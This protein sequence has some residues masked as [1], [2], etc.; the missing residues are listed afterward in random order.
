MYPDDHAPPHFH[1]IF[2]G[3]SALIDLRSLKIIRG[4]APSKVLAEAL[5]VAAA[6]LG[7]L[8]AKWEE[9]NERDD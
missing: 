7:D 4:D 6:N 2:P 1:L 5:D 3:G 8:R 9:L